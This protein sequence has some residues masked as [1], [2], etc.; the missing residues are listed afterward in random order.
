MRS[1]SCLRLAL[2]FVLLF[3]IVHAQDAPKVSCGQIHAMARI[4]RA[5]SISALVK[6]K[7][8]AG[9]SYRAEIVY[10]A[11]AFELRSGDRNAALALLK[12]LPENEVQHGV[13]MTLGDSLCDDEA[14]AEMSSLSRIRDHLGRDFAK[15]VLLVPN[16]LP[17]YVAY[18]SMSVQDP[19]SDYAAQMDPVC[20]AKHS[21]FVK[22]VEGLPTD[23]KAWF[24]GHVFNPDG[25]RAIALPEGE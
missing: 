19:H 10:S 25:C 17:R 23:Q 20:R 24:V 9:D 5:R 6:V 16:L 2:L 13:L 11:R 18:A 1:A 15:A 21:E 12:L 7:S 4:S 22:A 14:V 8:A 3:P